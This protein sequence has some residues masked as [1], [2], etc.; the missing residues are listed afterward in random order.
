MSGFISYASGGSPS[1]IDTSYER[2]G[3]TATGTGTTI[4]AGAP[5]NTKAATYTT[6]AASTAS[7][8]AG[9]WVFIQTASTNGARYA[10]DIA[11]GA[12]TSEVDLV[13]NFPALPGT[14]NTGIVVAFVPLNVA[15]GTRLSA[16]CK[17]SSASAS[18]TV[19]LLG[20]VRTA[21]HPPLW[22]SA[23]V[24]SSTPAGSPTPSFPSNTNLT[25]VSTSDTGW[26]TIA[27]STARTYG[28]L[29]TVLGTQTSEV[30]ADTAQAVSFRLGT[31]GSGATDATWFFSTPCGAAITQPT[32]PRFPS[33][34]I[35]KSIPSGTRLAGEVLMATTSAQNVFSPYVLGFY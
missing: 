7:A 34:P 17:S 10:I 1:N 13:P 31:G 26:T 2:A 9:F 24:V 32:I 29:V 21:N 20:E 25:G 15:A 28:A 14:A 18:C 6:L 22:N 33:L 19:S 5:A 35:Y 23:E 16:R 11:S 30:A 12:S 27:A 8:W 4:T 3:F